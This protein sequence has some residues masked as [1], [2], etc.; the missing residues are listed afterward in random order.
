MP[1]VRVIRAE[2]PAGKATIAPP[3]GSS[4]Q[5][6]GLDP[7]RVIEEINRL[8]KPYEGYN[9]KIRVIVD[10]DTLKYDIF[11]DLPSTTELLLKAAGV[12]E[13]SG[14]PKNKKIGN[15]SLEKIV[16]IA[17]FKK[18]ELNAKSLKAAVKTILGTARSIG[19]NIENKDPKEVIRDLEN[20]VYDDI[21]KK[22]ES[23]WINS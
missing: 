4:L 11:V 14:D 12:S 21:L 16:E 17:V 8:T 13:P 22:Y 9:V 1:G 2:V 10:L 19:L 3:L 20:G 15:V 7:S 6:L 18:R 5:Q 23:K